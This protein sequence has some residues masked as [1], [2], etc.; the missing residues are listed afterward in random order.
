MIYRT[1]LNLIR[2]K[3]IQLII[4]RVMTS[5]A[6]KGKNLKTMSVVA[7]L[8]ELGLTF[9]LDKKTKKTK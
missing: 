8:A 7:Y 6:V 3:L 1:I 4:R 5:K 9:L 2:L